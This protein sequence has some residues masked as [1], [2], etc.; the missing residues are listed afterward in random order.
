[1]LK[2][3]TEAKSKSTDVS[4]V[5]LFSIERRFFMAGITIQADVICF[6]KALYYPQKVFCISAKTD[7]EKLWKD[8]YTDVNCCQ[9]RRI[10]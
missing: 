2:H 5:V 7:V 6:C 1:M 8:Q 9:S 3:F 10:T 4:Q